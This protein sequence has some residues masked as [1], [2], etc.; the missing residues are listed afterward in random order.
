MNEIRWGVIGCG[1]VCE[2]KGGP[3]LYHTP[4]SRLVACHRRDAAAGADFARRHGP[5]AFEPTLDGLLARDDID[6]VYIATPPAFHA[7]QTIAAAAAGKHVL[8]EKPMAEDTAGCRAMVA[9]TAAASV[10]LAVAY[11]RRGYPSIQRLRRWVAEHAATE[12]WINARFPLSH[13]LDLLHDLGGT[14][15]SVAIRDELVPGADDRRGPVLHATC[16]NGLHARMGVAWGEQGHAP[17]QLGLTAADGAQAELRDLKAGDLIL[18]GAPTACGGLPWTHSGTVANLVAH[19][20]HGDALL[21][22][23]AEGLR[24]TVIMDYVSNLQPD[25]PELSVDY[26]DPP[27]FNRERAAAVNLLG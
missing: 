5:S 20:N 16:A 3:P 26:D 24:S 22:D 23:G 13:R 6:A 4:G 15:A 14:I 10:T 1:D 7:A 19:L 17:E 18:D 25:G 2:H 12:L 9:A 8:V 11:Y 27:P 21:C